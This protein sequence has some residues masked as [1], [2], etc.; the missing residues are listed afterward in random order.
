MVKILG[1]NL[2]LYEAGVASTSRGLVG[3]TVFAILP[4]VLPLHTFIITVLCQAV[5]KYILLSYG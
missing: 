5:R 4:N 1:L 2:N 3:D